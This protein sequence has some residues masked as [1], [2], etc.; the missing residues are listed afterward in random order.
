MSD[1]REPAGADPLETA[2]S[3]VDAVSWGEHGT[4][5]ELLGAEGREAVLRVAVKRGMD[6]ALAARLRDGTA[7]AGELNEF[8]LALIHGLRA[9]LEGADLDALEYELDP[10]SASPGQVR[11]QLTAPMP[12]ELG[13]G[14]PVGS[15]ELSEDDGAWKVDRLVP[16][17]AIIG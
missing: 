3:F 7:R 5:W 12:S 11:V 15:V 6:E 9:D 13:G 16:R 1:A 14:L 4:V 8:L 10:D 2:R 17:R